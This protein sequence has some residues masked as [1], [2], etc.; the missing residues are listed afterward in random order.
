MLIGIIKYKDIRHPNIAHLN[1]NSKSKNISS[2]H[3]EILEF[4]N[5]CQ[6]C[7]YIII[8]NSK[9]RLMDRFCIDLLHP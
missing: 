6:F 3:T 4:V 8:L 7:R 5:T 1:K 2:L 9:I